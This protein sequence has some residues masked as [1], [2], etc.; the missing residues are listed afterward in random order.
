[1]IYSDSEQ[2]HPSNRTNISDNFSVA[3]RL[4]NSPYLEDAALAHGTQNINKRN[5]NYRRFGGNRARRSPKQRNG[6]Y[7]DYRLVCKNTHEFGKN[8]TKLPVLPQKLPRNTCSDKKLNFSPRNKPFR[9]KPT[10]TL[11]HR[12]TEFLTRGTGI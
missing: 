10:C 5:P 1:M 2:L 4:Q 9:R 12:V 6:Y 11:K 3:S 8:D 7:S